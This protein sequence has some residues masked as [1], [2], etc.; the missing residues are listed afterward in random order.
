MSSINGKPLVRSEVSILSPLRYAGAK[1]RLSGYISEVLRLN[2]LRPKLFVEPFAGGASVALQL[3]TEN[4]VDEI[5]LGERDPLV[6]SFWKIV[7]NDAEWLIDQIER[8]SITV[9]RW[10]HFHDGTFRSNRE[11]ALA[12]LFLN[13]TSFSGILADT[14]GPIGGYKQVSAYKV[15]CRF[16]V[17]T[18]T[19]RIRQAASLSERV[20]FISNGDWQKTVAKVLGL[21][22][23][24]N[25]VFFYFDPPFYS[26]AER[27]YRFY[28]GDK[29]H[30]VLHRRVVRIRQP[31][32]LSYDAAVPIIKLYSHNGQGPRRIEHLYSIA[33]SAELVRAEELII[34]NLSKLPDETR[35]WRSTTEWGEGADTKSGE[36]RKHI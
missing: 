13:R 21:R 18:L 25:E 29:E 2:G 5:A 26:K 8:M 1:R 34:T 32:L 20:L 7:F 14:S 35:I 3:L 12:C 27:L 17:A 23:K 15:D 33:Q 31:W 24:K 28:F 10:R 16:P 9:E 22:Y 36:T 4:L 11:R 30:E 19:K 6:A